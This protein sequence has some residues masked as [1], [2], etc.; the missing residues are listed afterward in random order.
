MLVGYKKLNLVWV[1]KLHWQQVDCQKLLHLRP[2]VALAFGL[3]LP[4]LLVLVLALLVL[5]LAL[6]LVHFYFILRFT[7]TKTTFDLKE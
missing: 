7:T 5:A 3:V 4:L 6:V 1:L 2:H